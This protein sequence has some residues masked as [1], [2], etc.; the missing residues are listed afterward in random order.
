MI[1]VSKSGETPIRIESSAKIIKKFVSA[2]FFPYLCTKINKWL[3]RY[4]IWMF[5]TSPNDLVLRFFSRIF[6]FPSLKDRRWDSLH[7]TAR[8]SQLLCRY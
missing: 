6:R 2:K 1:S 5:R 7:E 4:P 3:R 8:E